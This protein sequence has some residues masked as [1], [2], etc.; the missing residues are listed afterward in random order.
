[1]PGT[2]APTT[3]YAYDDNGRL[4]TVTY[5]APDS[6]T[7]LFG[8][9]DGG[10]LDSYT[11]N[12]GQQFTFE[13]DGADRLETINYLRPDPEPDESVQFTYE[14]AGS[15]KSRTERNGDLTEF[16]RDDLDR[17]TRETFVPGPG[18]QSPPWVHEHAYDDS[19]NRIELKSG[20]RS[21]ER[22]VGKEWRCRRWSR[23]KRTQ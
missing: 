17:V 7:E 12:R 18:S 9:D 21:E 19:S 4:T 10:R 3:S 2:G 14:D 20:S 15:V 5:P 23:T 8:Y 13:Y 11:D 16:T 6:T 22:R 1:E